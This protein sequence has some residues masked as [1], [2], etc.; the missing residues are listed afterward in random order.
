MC[1][2]CPTS[3]LFKS[4]L[5]AFRLI[6]LSGT[7]QSPNSFFRCQVV[8]SQLKRTLRVASKFWVNV[9]NLF[10]KIRRGVNVRELTFFAL[11]VS[12]RA[13]NTYPLV[14][15][16]VA[17]IFFSSESCDSTLFKYISWGTAGG[18]EEALF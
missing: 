16:S 8:P 17:I 12:A 2:G 13:K 9:R 11:K 4:S 1:T 14:S 3:C 15:N 5:E 10:C 18:L 7:L 6:S